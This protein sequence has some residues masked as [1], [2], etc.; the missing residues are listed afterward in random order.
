MKFHESVQRLLAA[1]TGEQVR[2]TSPPEVREMHGLL[3]ARLDVLRRVLLRAGELTPADDLRMK[4]MTFA[5]FM[6]AGTIERT[7]SID[8]VLAG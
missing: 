8:E 6:D 2:E 1:A 7:Y 3:E 4:R 5:A